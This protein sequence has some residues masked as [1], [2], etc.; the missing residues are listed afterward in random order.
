MVARTWTYGSAALLVAGAIGW[1]FSRRRAIADMQRSPDTQHQD[2]DQHI[3]EG[4]VWQSVS[5]DV[6]PTLLGNP[7]GVFEFQQQKAALIGEPP[8]MR[9]SRPR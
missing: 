6:E 2:G 5:E 1:E 7:D 9:R 8:A 4:D 3:T